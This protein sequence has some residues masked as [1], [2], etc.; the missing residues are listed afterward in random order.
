VQARH[1]SVHSRSILEPLRTLCDCAG[2]AKE[3]TGKP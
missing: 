2:L 3:L 1:I